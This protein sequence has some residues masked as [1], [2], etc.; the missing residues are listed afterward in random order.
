MSLF[1]LNKVGQ[2]HHTTYKTLGRHSAE[3]LRHFEVDL[4]LQLWHT[5][6][7]G[8]QVVKMHAVSKSLPVDFYPP[9]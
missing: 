5:G 1:S 6:V 3:S 4:K 9:P 7:S 2:D 8:G